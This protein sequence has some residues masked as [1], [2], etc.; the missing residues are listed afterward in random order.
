MIKCKKPSQTPSEAF[1]RKQFSFI[2]GRA[3]LLLHVFAVLSKE[4]LCTDLAYFLPF[5]DKHE[6][7]EIHH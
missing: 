3:P 2:E 5:I 4:M 1:W 7:N 6:E